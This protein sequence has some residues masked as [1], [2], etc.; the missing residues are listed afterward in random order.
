MFSKA[1]FKQSCKA[2]G[3]MWGIITIAICFMLACLMLICGNGNIAGIKYALSDTIIEQEIQSQID[4][5]S[6]NYHNMSVLAMQKFSDEYKAVYVSTSNPQTA[7]SAGLAKVAQF[8]NS[9]AASL[10]IEE[11]LLKDEILAVMMFAFAPNAELQAVYTAN[12]ETF[13][14]PTDIIVLTQTKSQDEISEFLQN[15]TAIFIAAQMT[16]PQNIS[17]MLEQ[18][19]AFDVDEEKYNSFGFTY[20]LIKDS[21]NKTILTYVARLKYAI[22]QLNPTDYST[23]QEFEAAKQLAA[24]DVAGELTQSFLSNLPET[25]SSSLQEIGQMDLFGMVIGSIFYKIAGLLLPIIYII[26]VSNNLVA[27]QV[28]SGSMAYVLSTST[29]R[30]TVVFT[31]ALFLIGSLFAMCV[32]LSITSV[33]CLAIINIPTT[34]NYAQILL[35][36]LGA[37]VTLFAISG[38]CFLT[39]CW[40]DRSKKSMSIGG[41]ISMF[42]LV[43]AMLGLFASKIMP[44]IV[45]LDSLNFFNYVSIIT[46]FDTMSITSSSLDY[47]WKLAILL[48]VGIAGYI[49]GSIRFK[50]K[51]LPL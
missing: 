13:A 29:K 15:T 19:S 24:A 51:D 1:L 35:L 26:M 20:D 43:A 47:L 45:R 37:F 49:I 3:L 33:V 30:S 6:I 18:L 40:F 42:F 44:S 27:G 46:L 9:Y 41:G 2:N 50:K 36:N 21:S 12:G 16:N 4:E 31:Q 10:A 39:S 7:Y 32:C 34:I 17:L 5:R 38:I 23:P 8:A 11:Q 48:V 22:G 25:V 14:T 28:D